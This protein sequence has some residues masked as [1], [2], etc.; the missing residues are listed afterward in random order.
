MA[1]TDDKNEQKENPK[2]S[3]HETTKK[4][5]QDGRPRSRWGQQVRKH[6]THSEV[7]M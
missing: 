2:G 4:N 7:K 6:V 1:W 5:K 3:E